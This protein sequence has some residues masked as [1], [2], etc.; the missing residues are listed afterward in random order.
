MGESE[1]LL[2]PYISLFKRYNGKTQRTRNSTLIL[3]PVPDNSASQLYLS[4]CDAQCLSSLF[5]NEFTEKAVTTEKGRGRL[6]HTFVILMLNE[7]L[8]ILFV[9][10]WQL[11]I[12]YIKHPFEVY[13]R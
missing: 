6:F 2:C 11:F 8:F 1:V 10:C 7:Y 12:Q 3:L 13:S 5:L 9:V 4:S